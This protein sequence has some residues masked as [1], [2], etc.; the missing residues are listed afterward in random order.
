MNFKKLSLKGKV[1]IGCL[2]PVALL[3]TVSIVSLI[4]I[5]AMVKSN[6]WVQH[7]HNVLNQGTSIVGAAVD[8]E[9]GMRGFL[10]AGKEDFLTPYK[11]GEKVLYK[12]IKLLQETVSDNP[13]Q[14]DRLN[15][16]EKTLKE[17]QKVVTEP[18]IQLRKTVG[19][20]KTMDDMADL[21]G[22]ARG[23]KYF[24]KFRQ[25]MAEFSDEEEKL[26][27]LRRASN[28]KSIKNAM[29]I[30]VGIAV[31]SSLMGIF[32][33]LG[34][35]VSVMKQLGSDPAIIANIAN[36][37]ASGDFTVNFNDDNKKIN[38]VYANMKHM[39]E[40]LSK[41]FSDI[42][43]GVTTI[44]SSSNALSVLSE[45][46]TSGT[47]QTLSK[48]NSVAASAEEMATNMNS[49]A[50]ATEE[51]TANIQMIV[52]SAEEMS[53]TINE[54]AN[55]TA[56]GRQITSDAVKES[57][58]VS[59]KVDNLSRAASEISKVTETIADISEQTNLLALNATIEAARAGEAGKGFAVVAGEI[60][61]LAQQT[62]EATKEI[63]VKIAGVQSTTQE[64]IQAIKS[65][66]SII[67]EINNIVS[68]VAAAI[69]EQSVTTQEI[70]NN[71]SQAAAGL[72]EV[73]ENVN[74]TSS[75]AEEITRDI[76]EV[77]RSTEE[78]T[79][80]SLQVNSSSLELSS[81]AVNLD[82]M[83]AHFR[84]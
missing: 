44:T 27:T 9:T 22:E 57:Q 59:E 34:I 40:N 21:V 84:V 74:Q 48:S 47:E 49:V 55:N 20:T 8:M 54:I 66:V 78:I 6:E 58:K 33:A 16:I 13:K 51:V 52:S 39:S 46:M 64:S 81:L 37:I 19:D 76:T 30:I 75:V 5:N 83:V 18:A 53:A 61:D 12:R 82:K 69:E 24:D 35:T 10:L 4:N 71:V 45:Q 60:K 50:A 32:L 67:D 73:N 56:T 7:T 68:T 41:V 62:A 65:I 63:N 72:Q 77:N 36:T 38:G 29:T 3:V 26:M 1:I 70:S 79:T 11:N 23:K 25:L 43:T 17:W 31:L 28:S 2:T 15:E 80:G 42:S 14:V